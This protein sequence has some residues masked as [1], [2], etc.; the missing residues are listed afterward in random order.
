VLLRQVTFTDISSGGAGGAIY[1]QFAA[2]VITLEDVKVVG[3]TSG[4][5]GGFA[6]FVQ[7]GNTLSTLSIQGTGTIADSYY[8]SIASGG[9]GGVFYTEIS[10]L[11]LDTDLTEFSTITGGGG[12][13]ILFNDATATGGLQYCV[14][15]IDD[16][17]FAAVTS[18]GNGGGFN[19]VTNDVTF[20]LEATLAT[21]TFTG[22]AATA[23]SGGLAYIDTQTSAITLTSTLTDFEMSGMAATVDGGGLYVDASTSSTVTIN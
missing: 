1:A 7:V 12:G 18:A 22:T 20:T 13:G 2:A 21:S 11:T 15:D 3:S 19:L 23:G 8:K 5:T 16:C 6:H 9:D 14:I 17:K 4:S 10:R